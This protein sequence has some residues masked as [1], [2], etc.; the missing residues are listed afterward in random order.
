MVEEDNKYKKAIDKE[1]KGIEID[2]LVSRL[3]KKFEKL[4]FV[5]INGVVKNK[6]QI[7]LLKSLTEDNAIW[8]LD[9]GIRDVEGLIDALLTCVDNVVMS[10]KTIH[11]VE[12]LKV[13]YELSENVL[14]NI[15]YNSG[16]VGK[17]IKDADIQTT[18]NK[19]KQFGYQRIVFTD[20]REELN[21]LDKDT[22]KR[23]AQDTTIY[24]RGGRFTHVDKNE[25]ENIGI[26]GVFVEFSALPET[27]QI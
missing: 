15:E 25:L 7:K 5:D 3:S 23:I 13:A 21:G 10:T 24:L 1:G 2:E 18:V 6:P 17:E 16:I 9:A 4:L 26:A 20:I 8:L 11:D 19:I 22:L 27:N 14:P 12:D